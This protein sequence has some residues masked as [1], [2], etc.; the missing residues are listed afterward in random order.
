[1]KLRLLKVLIVI[2]FI[3]L[4]GCKQNNQDSISYEES[5]TEE[6][7]K[8]EGNFIQRIKQIKRIKKI[9]L[10]ADSRFF[11]KVYTIYFE[12]YIDHNNKDLG[13][14]LQRIEFGY[15]GIELPTVLVTS[16]YMAPGDYYSYSGENE[17][18]YLLNCNYLNMEH[19]YFGESL[20]VEMNYDNVNWDYLTTEQAAADAHDIV[21]QFKRALD[22]KWV[23]TGGSKSGMTTE[24]FA[25]YYP[26]DVDLYAPYVAPF[27]NSVQDSRFIEF[28][29]EEAGDQQYGKERAK[30]IRDEVL[31]FQLKL[32]EYRDDFATK[33]DNEAKRMNVTYSSYATKDNVYDCAVLE[34]CV[35]F[36]QYYQ[37][38]SSL[39]KCLNMP[40]TNEDEV[41]TKKNACYKYFSSI[42][43]PDDFGINNDFTPYYIQAWQELGNYSYDFDYIRDALEDK[44]LLTVTK[45]E[46]KELMFKMIL[47]DEELKLPHRELVY[48]KINNMLKTTDQQ[49][50]IIYGSSD[51]WY[52]V[53]P[54]DV[55]GRDNIN[56]YVNTN[57]PHTSCI[58][59]FDKATSD[60]IIGKIKTILELK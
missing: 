38:Y 28:L 52:A 3:L 6:T 44:S 32:L 16:G 39:E 46:D 49:F 25:L 8:L 56:I 35:G 42:I 43:S 5:I 15:N 41:S 40:E 20:P 47:S 11:S 7:D 18:A 9:T 51:P 29:Y 58:E 1:M 22:G 55:T 24:L 33:F 34:F 57:Y 17:I 14:F 50:I 26:G 13:T 53:R 30:E 36:W 60:E 31:E 37:S 48:Q 2:P 54:D 59:N 12:Q 10:T 4:G 23:S 45:E 19:R 27:C 21:T